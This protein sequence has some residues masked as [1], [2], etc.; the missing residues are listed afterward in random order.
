MEHVLYASEWEADR[1]VSRAGPT[2]NAPEG[3]CPYQQ[4]DACAARDGRPLGCRLHFCDSRPG[5]QAELER[6]SSEMHE[7]L[8]RL[9]DRHG[10]AWR[11]A[12]L[13]ATLRDRAARSSRLPDA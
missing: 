5:I 6:L 10:R 3:R 7:A 2:G 1:L 9:H 11:Y 4:G 12:P 13:L 8:K